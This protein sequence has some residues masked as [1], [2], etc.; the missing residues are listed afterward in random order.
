VSARGAVV[1]AAIVEVAA[2]VH[3]EVD[4]PVPPANRI[5]RLNV[6]VGSLCNAIIDDVRPDRVQRP[7]GTWACR[8]WDKLQGLTPAEALSV[9]TLMQNDCSRMLVTEERA[10]VTVLAAEGADDESDVRC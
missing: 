10:R 2:I 9:L 6:L 4:N 3:S 8:V 5:L 1:A 7:I